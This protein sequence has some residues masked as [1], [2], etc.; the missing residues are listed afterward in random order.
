MAAFSVLTLSHPYPVYSLEATDGRQ[1]CVWGDECAVIWHVT[2]LKEMDYR[3][4]TFCEGL[5]STSPPW[6]KRNVTD[7]LEET[8]LTDQITLRRSHT[9]K[10][11]NL[12]LLTCG[13]QISDGFLFK[14]ISWIHTG[15]G[16][17]AWQS[18]VMKQA[19]TGSLSLHLYCSLE[20]RT[21]FNL[22]RLKPIGFVSPMQMSA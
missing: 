14:Y 20:S 8:S 3:W 4:K 13:S 15:A 18:L 1:R 6:L 19:F 12:H 5:S 16:V 21:F 10:K 11:K 22:I 7:W 9:H 2:Q 17:L